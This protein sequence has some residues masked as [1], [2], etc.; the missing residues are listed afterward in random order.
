MKLEVC[1]NIA[2]QEVNRLM[3][4]V[5]NFKVRLAIPSGPVSIYYSIASD[6]EPIVQKVLRD[7]LW[8]T[9]TLEKIHIVQ[10]SQEATV[11]KKK[12]TFRPKKYT[13]GNQTIISKLP[14]K[15]E[16][17]GLT[18][19]ESELKNAM[20]IFE[21]QISD[22][23][24]QNNEKS[25]SAIAS[26]AKT[27][28]LDLLF[29]NKKLFYTRPFEREWDFIV[30]GTS[31]RSETS[32]RRPFP[33]ICINKCNSNFEDLSTFTGLIGGKQAFQAIHCRASQLNRSPQFFDPSQIF[34]LNLSENQ[35]ESFSCIYPNLVRLNLSKNKLT[36]IEIPLTTSKLSS[37]DLSYNFLENLDEV[38]LKSPCLAEFNCSRN[39]LKSLNFSPN[40]NGYIRLTVLNASFNAITKLSGLG[41][42]IFMRD[43]DLSYNKIN[44]CNRLLIMPLLTSLKVSN[45]FAD[46]IKISIHS[47]LKEQSFTSD[48]ADIQLAKFEMRMIHSNEMRQFIL[49][50]KW[51]YESLV[52]LAERVS[53]QFQRPFYCS[54]GEY[55]KLITELDN[56]LD[57][58]PMDTLAVLKVKHQFEQNIL[59]GLNT[60]KHLLKAKANRLR[61]RA[62]LK[63]QKYS[64]DNI[65]RMDE[66]IEGIVERSLITEGLKEIKAFSAHRLRV[67]KFVQQRYRFIKFIQHLKV[68]KQHMQVPSEIKDTPIEEPPLEE[69]TD[70]LELG[71]FSSFESKIMNFQTVNLFPKDFTPNIPIIHETDEDKHESEESDDELPDSKFTGLEFQ[72][73]EIK[74]SSNEKASFGLIETATTLDDKKTSPMANTDTS[75][76]LRLNKLSLGSSHRLTSQ[77]SQ[78]ENSDTVNI[79][80]SVKLRNKEKKKKVKLLDYG[81]R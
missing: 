16:S 56:A 44:D 57:G 50:T 70:V 61:R 60:F 38:T 43:L 31:G 2:Y 15:N 74:P 81:G 36:R 68:E 72:T 67:V 13:Y 22:F 78:Q 75:L 64:F 32:D 41:S 40:N 28:A 20:R 33:T 46:S 48:R 45:A 5:T 4:Q 27:K 69:D 52:N 54:T 26:N 73:P 14:I 62:M 76:K 79:I 1:S 39:R 59:R 42:A 80:P 6:V 34:E 25:K 9:F 65:T 19:E 53:N 11:S 47:F 35:L 23:R 3:N 29:K 71:D 18:S 21:S 55:L 49:Q 17:V 66:R 77:I 10:R 58:K 24:A 8:E 12:L 7:N 51:L 63:K 30:S 37:V